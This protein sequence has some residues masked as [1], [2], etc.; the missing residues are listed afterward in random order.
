[1]SLYHYHIVPRIIIFHLKMSSRPRA[2]RATTGR[3]NTE[4]LE[5]ELLTRTLE[6]LKKVQEYD[7]KQTALSQ[8]IL[9][10]EADMKANGRMSN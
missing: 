2:G 8:E 5:N 4:T 3:D 7:E 1:M 10:L 6:H 9:E